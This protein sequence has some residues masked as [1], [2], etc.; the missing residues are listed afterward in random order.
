MQR[1]AQQRVYRWAPTNGA[2]HLPEGLNAR[3]NGSLDTGAP[4]RVLIVEDS[5]PF[6]ATLRAS[7]EI[8][9]FV[10]DIASTV[11]Q[12]FQ[13]MLDAPPGLVILDV[14]LPGRDGYELLRTVRGCGNDVP[15]IVL[16]SRDDEQEKLH[17]FGLGADDLITRPVPLPELLARIRAL[18]RRAHP[19][20]ATAPPRWIRFGDIELCPAARTVKR[21]G[22][23]IDLRP[24]EFD[25]L[26][27]LFRQHDRVVSRADLLRDVWGY[28]ASTVSRTVDTHMAGLRLKLE[29]DPL[30]PRHLLTV[31]TAG[32]LLRQEPEEV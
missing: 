5:A 10:V 27:A 11:S 26:L 31:R 23:P 9:G 14:V 13:R 18:L 4:L 29:V 25:L 24:K 30:H 22:T 17:G 1:S 7:L 19:A 2:Q 28:D 15:V 8:E 32:Y 21:A 6:A 3:S 16:M 20:L 12:G